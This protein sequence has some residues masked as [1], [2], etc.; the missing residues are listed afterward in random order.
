M[1]V[2][3]QGEMVKQRKEFRVLVQCLSPTRPAQSDIQLQAQEVMGELG[4]N[5]IGF[6]GLKNDPNIGPKISPNYHLK[7]LHKLPIMVAFR[8]IM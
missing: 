4:G 5:S 1:L 7:R 3:L 8:A 6:L 2:L